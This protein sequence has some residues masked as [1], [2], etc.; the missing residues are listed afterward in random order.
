M[1]ESSGSEFRVD[2]M[3][4]QRG[5]TEAAPDPKQLILQILPEGLSHFFFFRGRGYG[6][7]GPTASAPICRRGSPNS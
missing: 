4:L 6:E 2:V 7:P 3:D 5:T 1:E